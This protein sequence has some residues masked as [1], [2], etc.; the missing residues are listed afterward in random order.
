MQISKIILASA[1]PYRMALLQ[2]TGLEFVT[3]SAAIDEQ[4]IVAVDPPTVARARAR[5]KAEHVAASNHGALVIGADQVLEFAGRVIDKAGS[6]EEATQCLREFSGREH[7]LHAAFCLMMHYDN[8]MHIFNDECISADM[9]LRDLRDAD[10][11][12]YVATGEWQ[13][14]VGCYRYESRGSN[15]FAAIRGEQSTIIG[16]PLLPLLA[17]LRSLGIDP[18]ISPH[19][20]WQVSL[21]F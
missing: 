18:L 5:A 1:S 11:T 7:Q 8:R 21:P 9:H 15:L 12:A 14:C 17:K 3:Q 6:A 2:S 13:G 4:A 20:P 16:L 19:G 10:I